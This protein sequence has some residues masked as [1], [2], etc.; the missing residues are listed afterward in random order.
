LSSGVEGIPLHAD[1]IID[2]LKKLLIMNFRNIW[3][4]VHL[5]VTDRYVIGLA[6]P[7]IS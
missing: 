2:W 7:Y 4:D 3:Q 1:G 5:K 6:R